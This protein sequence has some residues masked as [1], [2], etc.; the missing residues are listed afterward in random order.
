MASALRIAVF[1]GLLV[2]SVAARAQPGPLSPGSED[3]RAIR[4][5]VEAQLAAFRAGDDE[6]AFSYAAPAIRARFG[7]AAAFMAMVREGYAPL[8]RPRVVE[9]L[10]AAVI[11]GEIIQAVR[12]AGEDGVAKVA[13][14][15]MERQSDG[16]WKIKGCDLAPAAAV[17]A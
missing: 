8:I 1:L 6:A 7:T 12:V 2:L 16:S 13:L 14:Y 3:A 4:A 15:F 9:F 17:S 10:P 11:G 5:V